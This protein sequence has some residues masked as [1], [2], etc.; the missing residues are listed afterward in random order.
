M[1]KDYLCFTSIG[2]GSSWGYGET[3][4][5]AVSNMLIELKGWSTYYKLSEV[6][7][8]THIY[9]V[10]DYNG[11]TSDHRGLYGLLDDD[12]HTDD[13]L[14]PISI[15]V[16][17]TPKYRSKNNRSWTDAKAAESALRAR[18]FETWQEAEKAMKEII[19]MKG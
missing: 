19:P 7:M 16:V 8:R 12:N 15:A 17:T 5:E 1:N 18:F 10:S 2:G 6:M 11:F 9:D 3:P 4:A 13:P 14:S